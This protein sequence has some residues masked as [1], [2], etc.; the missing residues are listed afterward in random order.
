[1]ETISDYEKMVA[2]SIAIQKYRSTGTIDTPIFLKETEET[3]DS[4]LMVPEK[5]ES[6]QEWLDLFKWHMD[7]M[8]YRNWFDFLIP[9]LTA[10]VP[11]PVPDSH[12]YFHL[13]FLYFMDKERNLYCGKCIGNKRGWMKMGH[14]Y[15]QTAIPQYCSKCSNTPLQFPIPN[16]I[17]EFGFH[18]KGMYEN[19]SYNDYESFECLEYYPL[20]NNVCRFWACRYRKFNIAPNKLVEYDWYDDIED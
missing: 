20:T 9:Q 3:Y 15:R 2:S 1:M 14:L 5:Q 16:C 8:Y 4:P 17:E 6:Y 18:S 10:K 7:N 19:P 13:G 12:G 11:E